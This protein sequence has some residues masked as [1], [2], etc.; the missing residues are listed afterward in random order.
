MIIFL[1]DIFPASLLLASAAVSFGHLPAEGANY[2]QRLRV[3]FK[4]L[5]RRVVMCSS[6]LPLT[7]E[8]LLYWVL[9][10]VP[11]KENFNSFYLG[12]NVADQFHK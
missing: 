7:P 9:A 6:Y 11:A 2:T 3:L 10:Y 4:F 5:H 12:K 8:K 1:H